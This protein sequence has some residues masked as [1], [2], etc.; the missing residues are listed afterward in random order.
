MNIWIE[1]S[2]INRSNLCRAFDEA[3][4]SDFAMLQTIQFV[5]RWTNFRLNNGLQLDIMT[6]MK[7]L[8]QYTFDEYLSI[9]TIAE[10]KN[11]QVPF[12]HINQLIANKKAVNRPKDAIDVLELERIK[13]YNNKE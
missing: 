4:M 3:D 11:I 7:G 13:K 1:D 2:S 6:A 5:P 9:A 12:L 10:I 8:E